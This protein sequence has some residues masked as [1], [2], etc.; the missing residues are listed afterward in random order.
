M[1]HLARL[2][3]DPLA[4]LYAQRCHLTVTPWDFSVPSVAAAPGVR[5]QGL[6]G[7]S[8]RARSV[9]PWGLMAGPLPM[10]ETVPWKG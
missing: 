3:P 1:P 6:V 8:G 10:P 4:I 2:E 5:P 7:P 9:A